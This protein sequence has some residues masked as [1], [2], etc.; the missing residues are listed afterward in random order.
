MGVQ[1]IMQYFIL[2][3]IVITLLVIGAVFWFKSKENTAREKAV[4]V[5][6]VDHD[7][8][9][10]S[11][12]YI[13]PPEP[14]IKVERISVEAVREESNLIEIT[15]NKLLGHINNIIPGLIQAGN[16]AMNAVQGVQANGEV[17]YRAIIPV[18]EI[19]ADSKALDG[20]VRG[21][22]HG[23]DGIKGH[24]NLIPVD[25]QKGTA[26]VSNTIAGI[27]QI[28]SLV[29]G[30]Y[31]MYQINAKIAKI[32]SEINKISGFQD[33]EYRSRV[34][35]LIA[36]MKNISAFQV[37]ILE[38]ND[39][40]NSKILQ[41]DRLEEECTQ[42]LGQANLTIAE[43]TKKNGLKYADYEK[44]LS[45][46]QNWFMY[47]KYLLDVL[48]QIIEL[49]YTFYL[50]RVS[51]EQCG[52]LLPEYKNLVNE[53]LSRL[54]DWH[55]ANIQRLKID[56]SRM[57]RKKSA[58]ELTLKNNLPMSLIIVLSSG[59]N[60][61]KDDWI[62]QTIPLTTV[63]MIKDQTEAGF[64]EPEYDD[65]DLYSENVQLISK[66]GKLYYLPS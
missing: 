63:R 2:G 46:I 6:I 45:E 5:D 50:G 51:K 32:S 64:A 48:Y 19:L 57:L 28:A 16:V 39:L 22:Y 66:H 12:L 38:N 29:V 26:V 55:Q 14:V 56:T 1:Q 59:I 62:Y 36:Y 7:Q 8:I 17:L 11:P 30:Q 42:L 49:R 44:E 61:A 52:S 25:L 43:Y 3:I 21:F 15:D 53:T 34:I 31:Y 60:T 54:N 33:N 4:R 41:L 9:S 27:M 47:Q 40:R 35:S 58:A 24:A 37:E 65:M 20:A 18:G 23:A 10:K 13:N